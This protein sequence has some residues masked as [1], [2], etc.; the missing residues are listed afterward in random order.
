MRWFKVERNSLIPLTLLV[1]VDVVTADVAVTYD[2]DD[3]EKYHYLSHHV[4]PHV[5]LKIAHL[6][7]HEEYFLC[8]LRESWNAYGIKRRITL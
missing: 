5:I 4:I 1:I 3:I 8:D 7:L 6:Y 2:D